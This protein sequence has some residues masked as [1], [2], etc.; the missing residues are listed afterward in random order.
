MQRNSSDKRSRSRAQE[1]ENILYIEKEAWPSTHL[2]NRNED[3]PQRVIGGIDGRLLQRSFLLAGRLLLACHRRA[4]ITA[5]GRTIR[6]LSI[7]PR[8]SNRVGKG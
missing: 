1:K 7:A 5:I 8:R 3:R 4:D 2:S 6:R